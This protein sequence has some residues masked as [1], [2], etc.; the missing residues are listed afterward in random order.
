M[1]QLE[2]LLLDLSK[3]LLFK[4]LFNHLFSSLPFEKGELERDF[5]V[6]KIKKS[7]LIPL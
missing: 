4:P 1:S 7:P 6:R 5:A 2:C 3:Y